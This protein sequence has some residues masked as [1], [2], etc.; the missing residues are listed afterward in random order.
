MSAAAI[1][2]LTADTPYDFRVVATSPA[3]DGHRRAVPTTPPL[4][5]DSETATNIT[6]TSATLHA[7]INPHRQ[8]ITS[9]STTRMPTSRAPAR[10]CD[11]SSATPV[12]VGNGTSDAPATLT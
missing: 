9:S 11:D 2:G 8:R 1:K 3:L 5:V 7:Q 4:S 12:D 6:A 10:G